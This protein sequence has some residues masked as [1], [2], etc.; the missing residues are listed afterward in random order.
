[1]LQDRLDWVQGDQFYVAGRKD[2]TVQVGG[3]NVCLD[4]VRK[5]LCA[6]P[7]VKD[8]V[9][10]LHMD[11]LKSFI[12]TDAPDIVAIEAQIRKHL[13][14]LPA[15]ARPDRFTF[16]TQFPRSSMGKLQDW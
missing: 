8:A 1:M 7:G 15:P 13:Y 5:N 9:V 10:R 3:V 16:G 12:V 14:N 4:L 2:S 6:C 11:R